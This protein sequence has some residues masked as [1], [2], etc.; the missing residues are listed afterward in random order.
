MRRRLPNPR[1]PRDLVRAFQAL[2]LSADRPDGTG[3]PDNGIDHEAA[4]IRLQLARQDGGAAW[5]DLARE[6]TARALIRQDPGQLRDDLIHAI[7]LHLAWLYCLDRRQA[8]AACLREPPKPR[9][10]RRLMR[11]ATGRPAPGA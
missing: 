10:R 6:A 9:R 8:L 1:T 2:D 7:A 5:A 3:G 4:L 11:A